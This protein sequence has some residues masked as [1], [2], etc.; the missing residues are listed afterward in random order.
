M[1]TAGV[2]RSPE[3]ERVSKKLPR[4]LLSMQIEVYMH[5]IPR[6]R[7]RSIIP[8]HKHRKA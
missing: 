7:L 5:G 3:Q 2:A 8:N 4:S 6:I 1:A